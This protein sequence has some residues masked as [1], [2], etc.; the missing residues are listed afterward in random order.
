MKKLLA[1]FILIVSIFL[2]QLIYACTGQQSNIS[3]ACV[4]DQSFF[5]N[6]KKCLNKSCTA[7]LEKKDHKS[8]LYLDDLKLQSF[9]LFFSGKEILLWKTEEGIIFSD[10]YLSRNDKLIE[11]EFLGYLDDICTAN[12]DEIK[13]ILVE[14]I[15]NS[16]G[17]LS[18]VKYSSDREAG[19][20]KEKKSYLDCVYQDY[21]RVGD[22]LLID[23]SAER[24]YCYS[25]NTSVRTCPFIRVSYI[26][27]FGFLL[28]NLNVQ[29]IPYLIVYLL[30]FT[31]IGMALIYL[32]RRHEIGLF[33]SLKKFNL[34]ATLLFAI[35]MFLPLTSLFGMDIFVES[36]IICYIFT[37]LIKYIHWRLRKK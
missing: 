36:V 14:E 29:A 19:L 30:F 26:N 37:T 7:Y 15:N 33:F 16:N 18:I 23:Y 35:L 20:I 1:A 21:K 11:Q 13:P 6:D 5:A 8:G 9:S 24:S 31:I 28:N 3:L 27:F 10:L 4:P 32:A 22:W 17:S 34:I 12:I 2:P 25:M